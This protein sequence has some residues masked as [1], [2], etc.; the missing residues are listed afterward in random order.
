MLSNTVSKLGAY[1]WCFNIPRSTCVNYRTNLCRVACYA[2]RGNFMRPW[3]QK[4]FE[5]NLKE[6]KEPL[7]VKRICLQ[8]E[9][10]LVDTGIKRIRLHSSGEF[11]SK[12]YFKKWMKI[13]KTFPSI[14]FLAY[15]RN[16]DINLSPVPENFVIYFSI[17]ESTKKINKSSR[18]YSYLDSS[19]PGIAKH[20]SKHRVLDGFICNSHCYDCDY[21]FKGKKNIV[22]YKNMSFR[23]SQIKNQYHKAKKA[24]QIFMQKKSLTDIVGVYHG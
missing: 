15:T 3:I 5:R 4:V 21:C 8:I 19:T 14:R 22:F 13:S 12:T 24:G 7:F 17:D 10:I 1:V 2:N 9:D 6:S 16:T 11:Y 18:L 23:M 20:L